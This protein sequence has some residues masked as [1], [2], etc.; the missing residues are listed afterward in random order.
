VRDVGFHEDF[1]RVFGVKI[2]QWSSLPRKKNYI[3]CTLIFQN[4][5]TL[6]VEALTFEVEIIKDCK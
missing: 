6:T 1:V 5:K 3:N 2:Q 4:N